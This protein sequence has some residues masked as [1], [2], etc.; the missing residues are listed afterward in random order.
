MVLILDNGQTVT[1]YEQSDLLKQLQ[2]YIHKEIYDLLEEQYGDIDSDLERLDKLENKVADQ[3]EAYD[4][5]ENDLDSLR[6]RYD[7]LYDEKIE[8]E[9]QNNKIL[10]QIKEIVDLSRSNK[11]AFSEVE[12]KLEEI[13][14]E[15]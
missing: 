14:E 4:S 5:L 11:L 12:N 6:N 3:D 9:N 8:L 10:S 15:N 1:I 13:W 7:D 2:P